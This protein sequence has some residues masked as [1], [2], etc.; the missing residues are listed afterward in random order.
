MKYIHNFKTPEEFLKNYVSGECE[1]FVING[2]PLYTGTT[3]YG[4]LIGVV[5]HDYDGTYHY[6][7]ASTNNNSS[8]FFWQTD[9][10]KIAATRQRMVTV[11]EP[12]S[13]ENPLMPLFTCIVQTGPENE[14]PLKVNDVV[15]GYITP[16][17]S[18]AYDVPTNYVKEFDHNFGTDFDAHFYYVGQYTCNDDYTSG[19]TTYSGTTQ[20]FIYSGLDGY[21][22]SVAYYMAL[23][24]R[25]LNEIA[26]NNQLPYYKAQNLGNTFRLYSKKMA[27]LSSFKNVEYDVKSEVTYNRPDL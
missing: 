21:N 23:D 22:Q 7:S 1:S 17:V 26:A 5:S 25:D 14:A 11:G 15:G 19:G 9:D 24:S 12:V 16:W 3:E 10:G 6:V 2:G 18:L 4:E 27:Y 8:T 13:V 20:K